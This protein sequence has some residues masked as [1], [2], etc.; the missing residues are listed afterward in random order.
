MRRGQGFMAEMSYDDFVETD[1][2]GNGASSVSVAISWFGA[3]LSVSLVA[4]MGVWAWQLAVRDVSEVPVVRALEGPMRVQPEDPGG[5][6]ADYQ[7]LAV[8]RIPEA[9]EVSPPPDQ[10]VLAP[11]PVDLDPAEDKPAGA[12][13]ESPLAAAPKVMAEPPVAPAAPAPG[14]AEAPR[15]DATIAAASDTDRAVAEALRLADAVAGSASPLALKEDETATATTGAPATAIL[16]AP[17]PVLR[18]AVAAVATPDLGIDVDPGDLPVGTR[19]AQI[20]AYDSRDEAILAWDRLARRFGIYLADKKRL[21]QKTRRG[22]RDFY[23]LRVVGFAGL[24]DSR[25]FCSA[26]RAERVEC[27]PVAHR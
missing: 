9:G 26:L 16:R 10:I 15:G 20:G 8:N 4:G 6:A 17:R 1:A 11:P 19:L 18:P 22:G 13:Q 24:D 12:L 5:V 14:A 25:R 23:R 3:V 21:I 27:I 2:P 7:G